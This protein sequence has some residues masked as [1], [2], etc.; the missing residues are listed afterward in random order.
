MPTCGWPSSGCGGPRPR[1]RSQHAWPT[2]RPTPSPWLALIEGAALPAL[3]GAADGP[4]RWRARIDAERSRLTV[5]AAGR[6]GGSGPDTAV[7]ERLEAWRSRA[8]R[9]TK[10]A[11]AAVLHDR[12]L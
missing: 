6:P 8:A 11:A 1:S 7:V 10:T 12:T 4:A 3:A 5:A 9:A 2:S